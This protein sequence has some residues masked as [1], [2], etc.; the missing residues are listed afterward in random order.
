MPT[1]RRH[2]AAKLHHPP[3]RAIVTPT[4]R[5][6]GMVFGFGCLRFDSSPVFIAKD[7]LPSN[8]M[9]PN[10]FQRHDPEL[11]PYAFLELCK[12]EFGN[13]LI[14]QVAAIPRDSLREFLSTL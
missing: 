14:F 5:G 13:V 12:L 11:A 9:S 6:T 7:A 4:V 3:A 2:G 10:L 8:E 1:A